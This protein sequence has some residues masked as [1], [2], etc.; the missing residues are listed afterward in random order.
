MDPE[1]HLSEVVVV[2]GAKC[3]A[4]LV[5]RVDAT[6]LDV[7]GCHRDE[8]IEAIEGVPIVCG[9][10]RFCLRAGHD[11]RLRRH[12]VRVGDPALAL[13]E[14]QHVGPSIV[15]GEHER[16]VEAIGGKLL[17]GLSDVAGAPIGGPIGA[18]SLDEGEPILP[19]GNGEDPRPRRLAS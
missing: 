2:D 6:Q 19:G 8:L 18:E 7:K 1:R 10:K 13:H 12:P 9:I 5:E 15:P 11:G 3:L 16:R 4:S 14:L 17:R